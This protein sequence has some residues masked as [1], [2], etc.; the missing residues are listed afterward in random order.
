MSDK[1]FITELPNCD[2]CK[3]AE[4]KAVTAKYD[5]LT[6]YGSWAKMCKDCFQDYGKGLGIGQG[7]EL[8]LKTSQKEVK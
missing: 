5:G 1:V 8:I 4:E 3:S 6:I 7:Q 2:I